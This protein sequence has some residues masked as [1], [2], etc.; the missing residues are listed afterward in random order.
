MHYDLEMAKWQWMILC[1]GLMAL[2]T[3]LYCPV[4]TILNCGAFLLLRI[5]FWL[6]TVAV[7]CSLAV[8][9]CCT[10]LWQPNSTATTDNLVH[11][12]FVMLSVNFFGGFP[13]CCMPWSHAVPMCNF[14]SC[15][16]D[17]GNIFTVRYIIASLS[18]HE[19][20]IISQIIIQ[21]QIIV[22]GYRDTCNVVHDTR[23]RWL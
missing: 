20:R 23:T 15:Q 13:L 5:F 22:C 19:K 21:R 11:S 3:Q 14:P 10:I 7:K 8:A 16:K 12:H 18:A 6:T 9:P 17:V 4:V 2:Y 1:I